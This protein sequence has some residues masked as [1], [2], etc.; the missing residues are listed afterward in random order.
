MDPSSVTIRALARIDRMDPQYA[1]YWGLMAQGAL[2]LA[3]MT[4]LILEVSP[5]NAIFWLTDLAMKATDV[6]SAGTLIE[7]DFGLLELHAL[8]PDSIVEA[9]QVI[10]STLGRRRKDRLAPEILSLQRITGLT[11]YQSQLVNKVR[12]GTWTL[13]GESVTIVEVTPAGY[14]YP[15]ADAIVKGVDV[16]L[17]RCAGTGLFGRL[18][19]AGSEAAAEQAETLARAA[20]ERI[21][22]EATTQVLAGG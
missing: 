11:D 20:A 7:R 10:L 18:I 4:Q 22:A 13:P 17:V 3:G 5:S 14:A 16:A 21:R 2:P 15:L 12:R 6:R 8:I 1:A 9:E 19:I